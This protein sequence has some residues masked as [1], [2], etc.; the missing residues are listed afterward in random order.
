FLGFQSDVVPLMHTCDLIAHTSTAPE[1]FGRVIIE[2]ML[3]QKPVVAAAAGGVVE[4]I[5][6]GKTGWL[7]S[8]ESS[9]QLAEVICH[10]KNHPD[11]VKKVAELAK[12]KAMQN[13]KL[14]SINQQISQILSEAYSKQQARGNRQ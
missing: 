14:D 5:E 9:Q 13:F 3:C 10:I 7:F 1:P 11:K 2:G 12:I 4:L 8:P 6:N